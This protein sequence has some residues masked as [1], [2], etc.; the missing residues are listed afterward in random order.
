MATQS[1][2]RPT[3]RRKLFSVWSTITIVSLIVSAASFM[4]LKVIT[5]IGNTQFIAILLALAAL[6]VATRIR[7]MPVV[8]SV[9]SGFFLVVLV[10][11]LHF[12]VLLLTHPQYAISPYEVPV[13]VVILASLAVSFVTGIVAAVRNYQKPRA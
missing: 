2:S 5:S 10:F 13:I 12:V 8:G 9:L 4:A 11:F 7:W 3:F 1:T 6:L